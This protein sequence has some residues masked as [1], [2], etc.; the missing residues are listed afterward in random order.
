M[1][2]PLWTWGTRHFAFPTSGAGLS[3]QKPTFDSTS[4]R[5]SS[6]ENFRRVV[7]MNGDS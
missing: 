6:P 4:H 5:T 2:G 1:V 3:G 7:K